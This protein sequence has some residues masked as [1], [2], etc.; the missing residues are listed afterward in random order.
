[1][2]QR[3]PPNLQDDKIGSYVDREDDEPEQEGAMQIGPQTKETGEGDIDPW[4]PLPLPEKKINQDRKQQQS[5]YLRAES[6]KQRFSAQGGEEHGEDGFLP[7]E[8]PGPPD[9][10]VEDQ[11]SGEPSY[12]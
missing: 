9:A 11:E 6:L 8:Q 10:E 4:L 3:C 1:M 12:Q 5:D 2:N 7:E